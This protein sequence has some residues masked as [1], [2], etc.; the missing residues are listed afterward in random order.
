VTPGYY[1][2][3]GVKFNAIFVIYWRCE[4]QPKSSISSFSRCAGGSANSDTV[5][6]RDERLSK[7]R[8]AVQVLVSEDRNRAEQVQMI[9]SDMTPP[10]Q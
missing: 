5:M 2:I 7:L 3:E 1:G 10:P 9:F 8:R 4:P 6:Q